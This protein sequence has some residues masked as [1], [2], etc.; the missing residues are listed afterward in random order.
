MWDMQ[1]SELVLRDFPGIGDLASDGRRCALGGNTWIGFADLLLPEVVRHLSAGRGCIF[2]LAFSGD[3]RRLASVDSRFDLS[4]WDVSRSVRVAGFAV[5]RSSNWPDNAG[6]ALDET[7]RWLG[8]ASGGHK[9]RSLLVDLES[10]SEKR[11]GPWPLPAGFER[12]VHRG[13]RFLLVREEYTS[14]HRRSLQ[15]VV[16]ELTTR[17]PRLLRSPLRPA[18]PGDEGFHDSDL[19]D[20]GRYYAWAGPR[21]PASQLR[22]EVREVATGRAVFERRLAGSGPVADVWARL[23]PDARALLLNLDK[24]QAVYSLTDRYGPARVV[25]RN[26]YPITPNGR[27]AVHSIRPIP[28]NGS[29]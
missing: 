8:S 26:A 4:V 13:G 27:W 7:G 6:L 5:P 21:K 29:I 12:L 17:G 28:N 15:S 9:A 18:E 2:Q 23:T 16:R 14:E 19:S 10:T 24:H 3:S 22:V 11:F 20:D 1:S 25:K